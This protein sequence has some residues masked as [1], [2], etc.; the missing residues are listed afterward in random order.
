LAQPEAGPELSNEA[1]GQASGGGRLVRHRRRPGGLAR[2]PLPPGGRALEGGQI[3]PEAGDQLAEPPNLSAEG[4][5]HLTDVLPSPAVNGLLD[6]E[7]DF[8]HLASEKGV[9]EHLRHDRRPT[10]SGSRAA[11]LI[12]VNA[13]TTRSVAIEV[14]NTAGLGGLHGS[15]T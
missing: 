14:P 11:Q 13:R 5:G 9:R 7:L 3:L 12:A 2:H 8:G 4:H 1:G 6:G 15:T 10:K